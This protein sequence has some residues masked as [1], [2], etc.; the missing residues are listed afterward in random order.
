MMSRRRSVVG[1]EEIV[2]KPSAELFPDEYDISKKP[3]TVHIFLGTAKSDKQEGS[4]FKKTLND[5]DYNIPDENVHYL[6]DTELLE[7]LDKSRYLNYF[8]TSYC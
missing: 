8:I 4:T 2:I 7:C 5:Y 6:Q 3:P 1:D